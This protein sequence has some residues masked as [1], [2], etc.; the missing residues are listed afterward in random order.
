MSEPIAPD[1]AKVAADAATAALKNVKEEFTRKQANTDAAMSKLQ[2]QNED[3]MAKLSGIT[4]AVAPAAPKKD[5]SDLI[6]SDPEEY[7]RIIQERATAEATKTIQ[8]Q[9][10]NQARQNNTIATLTNEYPELNQND[11]ELT[12]RAIEIYSQLPADEQTS[13]LAY[14]LAVKEAA[15]EKGIK[16]R[17][18]RSE[19]EM[20]SSSS[21]GVKKERKPKLSSQTLAFAEA[22]GLKVDDKLKDRLEQVSNR[23]WSKYE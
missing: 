3:L 18:Q 21:S 14:K 17:S 9:L 19:E 10:N 23:N 22:V 5:L 11:H 7:T 4:A 2:K 1:A 15:M 13:P 16:P 6:Y 8:G 20:L 12:K